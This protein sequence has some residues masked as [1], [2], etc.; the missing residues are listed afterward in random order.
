[1]MCFTE[2]KPNYHKILTNGEVA[3]IFQVK[4]YTKGNTVVF[5]NSFLAIV[6]VLYPL[7]TPERENVS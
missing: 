6:P 1:M 2:E 3:Q 5:Y 7:K 4:D